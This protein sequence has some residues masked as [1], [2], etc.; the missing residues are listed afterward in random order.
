MQNVYGFISAINKQQN[1]EEQV[2]DWV[3]HAAFILFQFPAI[4]NYKISKKIQLKICCFRIHIII[5]IITK[6]R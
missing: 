5:I 3:T 2:D 4:C 1:N 6:E